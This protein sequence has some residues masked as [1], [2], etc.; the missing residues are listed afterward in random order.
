NPD[1][2]VSFHP[3]CS[4]QG[5]SK[6][7]ITGKYNCFV[8]VKSCRKDIFKISKNDLK[9]RRQFAAR[10]GLPLVFAIR[11]TLFEGQCYW[12][13]IDAKTLQKQGRKVKIDQLIGSLSA[14]LLNTDFHRG[15]TVNGCL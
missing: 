13:L 11:F 1:F 12:I 10:F 6:K 7:E 15:L 2:L 8:E 5:L 3:G 4:V 14:V 9:A